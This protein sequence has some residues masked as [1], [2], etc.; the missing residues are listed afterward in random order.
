MCTTNGK[1]HIWATA[2][3]VHTT[4]N[5][6]SVLHLKRDYVL[7]FNWSHECVALPI[8]YLFHK[9]FGD[10]KF[11][12]WFI[13][14]CYVSRHILTDKEGERERVNSILQYF[15]YSLRLRPAQFVY[16]FYVFSRWWN[17]CVFVFRL[18]TARCSHEAPIKEEKKNHHSCNFMAIDYNKNTIKF[19]YNK[20]IMQKAY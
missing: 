4:H 2:S 3:K 20:P 18:L 10:T 15:F 13:A 16:K 11:E 12:I 14:Y 7:Q 1:W 19:G 5:H 17:I 9:S 6:F 8:Q